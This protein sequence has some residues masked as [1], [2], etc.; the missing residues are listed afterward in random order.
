MESQFETIESNS[1]WPLADPIMDQSHQSGFSL[2]PMPPTPPM[3]K[4]RGTRLLR[5]QQQIAKEKLPS[6]QFTTSSQKQQTTPAQLRPAP[7]KLRKKRPAELNHTQPRPTLRVINPDPQSPDNSVPCSPTRGYHD[8][9]LTQT[10]LARTVVVPPTPVCSPTFGDEL[11]YSWPAITVEDEG[12]APANTELKPQFKRRS[13]RASQWMGPNGNVDR[14]KLSVYLSKVLDSS[15]EVIDTPDRDDLLSSPLLLSP[16]L[17]NADQWSRRGDDE[18]YSRRPTQQVQP[19]KHFLIA[20]ELEEAQFQQPHQERRRCACPP[21]VALCHSCSSQEFEQFRRRQVEHKPNQSVS[22]TKCI[23]SV[24]RAR[25]RATL[26]DVQEP[27]SPSE[28]SSPPG[29]MYDSEESEESDWSSP[30]SVTAVSSPA[31]SVQVTPTPAP[32]STAV[33]RPNAVSR[34]SVPSFSLPFTHGRQI[35]PRIVR[36]STGCMSGDPFCSSPTS[37]VPTLAS[38]STISTF[39]FDF[40]TEDDGTEYDPFENGSELSEIR[41]YEPIHKAKPVL[42]HCRGPS[43]QSIKYG[44]A[45]SQRSNGSPRSYQVSEDSGR[46]LYYR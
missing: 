29:L 45:Y 9:D 27:E 8:G 3:N 12:A 39:T 23:L 10:A 38:I 32:R 40:A 33:P 13:H 4:Q 17:D 31:P 14:K 19:S 16:Y 6:H 7:L 21:G 18:R 34:P 28:A 20:S 1:P 25:F 36:D 43:P 30:S 24:P 42:V 46:S 41:T 26:P 22:S 37:T 11:Q 15:F 5:D 35:T 2:F 44:H